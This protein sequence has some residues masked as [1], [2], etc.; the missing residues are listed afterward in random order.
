MVLPLTIAKDELVFDLS[1][2]AELATNCKPTKR[3]IVRIAA[4]FYDPLGFM[5]PI[6][7]QFKIMFQELCK[8]KVGWNE[9]IEQTTRIKWEK[10]VAQL[11]KMK[12]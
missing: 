12:L 8:S 9:E 6:T 3:N 2:I 1:S 7:I 10:L 11:V 4:K 5:S